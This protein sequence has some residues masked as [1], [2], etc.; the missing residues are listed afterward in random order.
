[1]LTQSQFLLF[2]H[3]WTANESFKVLGHFG[4]FF[5]DF[6][7]EDFPVQLDYSG[8]YRYLN[9][10]EKSMS[11]AAV[12]GLS[13]LSGSKLVFA[14]AVISHLAH[15][16]FLSSVETPHMKK[17]YGDSLRK[18]AGFTRTIRKV[19]S[20]NAKILEKRLAE[21][22]P[23]IKKVAE[24]VRG[25]LE[26]AFEE[27]ADALEEFL[28]KCASSCSPARLGY[29]TDEQPAQP[30]LVEVMQETRQLIQQSR[31][32]LIIPRVASNLSSYDASRYSVTL[33]PPAGCSSSGGPPRYHLGEPIR[34]HWKAPPNHSRRDWIGLYRLGANRSK[35]VTQ[36]N[37]QGHWRPIVDEEWDG[38][39]ALH[40]DP[41]EGQEKPREEGEVVFSGKALPW[42]RTGRFELRYHHDGLY[43]VMAISEPF[44]IYG[45]SLIRLSFSLARSLMD[46]DA[47]DQ[48]ESYD[49]PSVHALLSKLVVLGLD[50]DPA[51]V[52]ACTLPPAQRALSESADPEDFRFYSE[53]QAKRIAQAIQV[54]F[55]IE[56]AHE[57]VVADAKVGS[58]ARKIVEGREVLGPFVVNGYAGGGEGEK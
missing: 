17:L 56:L 26:K 36:V 22:A 19:A 58:L 12:W 25:T 27:T 4:W 18:E 45:A 33:V 39:T 53:E 48:P 11:G 54:A 16:W 49:Y 29:H 1:M 50:S 10:P 15:W 21:Q 40:T 5:G 43:N 6:F 37:S 51:L 23:E 9:N 35:K 2:L 8:I 57:V 47:V 28:A 34:V 44:E 32:R 30:K 7:I 41:A 31:D 20:K 52:P 3:T 38:D 55:G 13:L 24:E 14:L 42:D 46:R